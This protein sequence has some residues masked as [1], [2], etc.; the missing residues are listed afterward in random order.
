[1]LQIAAAIISA[2]RRRTRVGPTF[3]NEAHLLPR[4]VEPSDGPNA[5]AKGPRPP[6]IEHVSNWARQRF[7]FFLTASN[8]RARSTAGVIAIAGAP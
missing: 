5:T 1:M 3:V 7:T 4:A 8:R 2:G 6:R